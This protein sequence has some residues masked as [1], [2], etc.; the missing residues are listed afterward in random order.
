MCAVF[1]QKEEPTDCSTLLQETSKKSGG[2]NNR[3]RSRSRNGSGSQ[4]GALKRPN[5]CGSTCPAFPAARNSWL[6][7]PTLR[8]PCKREGARRFSGAFHL[9]HAHAPAAPAHPPGPPQSRYG[10]LSDESPRNVVLY[11]LSSCSSLRKSGTSKLASGDPLG[12]VHSLSK[13]PSLIHA[14]SYA[15][16]YSNRPCRRLGQGCIRCLQRPAQDRRLFEMVEQHEQLEL[17][18]QR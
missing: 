7:T 18:D 3:G 8:L 4:C 6:S 11:E 9:C 5:A 1:L 10:L 2:A 12:S 17:V 15:Y 14:F 13:S 16:F